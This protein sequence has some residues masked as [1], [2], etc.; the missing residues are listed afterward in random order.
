MH[1]T[2][3]S[4]VLDNICAFRLLRLDFLS[5]LYRAVVLRSKTRQGRIAT[6]EIGARGILVENHGRLPRGVGSAEL[7]ARSRPEE[8][9]Q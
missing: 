3:E 9:E 7:G 8:M 2:I 5:G 4:S 6:S 1:S